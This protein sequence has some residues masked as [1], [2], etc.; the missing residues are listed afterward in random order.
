[1]PC[2]RS[3]QLVV[4]YKHTCRWTR[5][6]MAYLAT[7][8]MSHD[9]RTIFLFDSAVVRTYAACRSTTDALD[10]GECRCRWSSGQQCPHRKSGVRVIGCAHVAP[11][12][13]SSLV[14]I[15]PRTYIFPVDVGRILAVVCLPV[16]G[17]RLLLLRC[18]HDQTITVM[19]CSSTL[20]A[21]WL[22]LVWRGWYTHG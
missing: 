4:F 9:H 21:S 11:S 6:T 10:A 14:V 3:R 8:S 5:I 12:E 7:F 1:M 2:G 17:R 19:H 20:T 13:Y 16:V 18:A 15:G 22:V